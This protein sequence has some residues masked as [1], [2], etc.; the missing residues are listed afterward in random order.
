LRLTTVALVG[1]GG[2]DDDLGVV[3][4]G[5]ETRVG[6]E[7]KRAQKGAG[8]EDDTAGH[9]VGERDGGEGADGRETLVENVVAE[10]GGDLGDA[11]VLKDDGVEVSET[12]ARELTEDGDHEHLSHS[13]AAVVGE[14]ERAV[15]PPH[16][17]DAVELDALPHLVDLELDELGVGVVVAVEL[18]EE[19]NGLLLAAVGHE[20]TGGLGEEHDGGHDDDAGGGLEDQG[21]APRVVAVN[22]VGA[23]GDDGGRDGTT[24]PT[25]VVE[26]GATATPVRG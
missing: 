23:E 10:L 15:V 9:A 4:G 24:E 25:A 7:G 20:E 19:G 2:G 3:E 6:G 1:A 16:L 18:D 11:E 13:P 21:N 17:V 14:E 26:T 12:V 22:V 5:G 8:D